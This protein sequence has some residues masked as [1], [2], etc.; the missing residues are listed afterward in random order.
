MPLPHECTWH[1]RF[2]H[3][4][5][6]ELLPVPPELLVVPPE[7]PPDP[8]LELVPPEPL[9]VPPLPEPLLPLDPVP[10]LLPAPPSEPSPELLPRPPLEEEVDA[11]GLPPLLPLPEENPASSLE[12]PQLAVSANAMAVRARPTPSVFIVPTHT[13]C[14]AEAP[15]IDD[16]ETQVGRRPWIGR[17]HGSR[18]IPLARS[19]AS[20]VSAAS[21]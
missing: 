7:P 14:G 1:S 8:P 5:P 11:S 20:T 12:L 13:H 2:V 16:A 4:V 6:P 19:G 17:G 18:T 15:A 3:G 9:A 21:A 10:E